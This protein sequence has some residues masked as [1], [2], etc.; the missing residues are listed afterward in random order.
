L[1]P[2]GKLDR[3]FFEKGQV[4]ETFRGK[5]IYQ[6]AIDESTKKLDEGQWVRFRSFSS[7]WTAL[8]AVR[9]VHI[10][11]EGRIKQDTLSELRRFKWGVSRSEPSFFVLLP[12]LSYAGREA[13]AALR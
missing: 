9:K 8:T 7:A 3:W 2:Q 5:G 10:F 1:Q 12:F 6:K 13:D 4:I 11:P